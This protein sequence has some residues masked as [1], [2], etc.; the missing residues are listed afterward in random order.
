[1]ISLLLH[2]QLKKKKSALSS[3]MTFKP[4]QDPNH[5]LPIPHPDICSCNNLVLLVATRFSPI[6]PYILVGD[7]LCPL[8]SVQRTQ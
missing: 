8:L 7:G 6:A 1:M 4:F 2:I 3:Q 5:S